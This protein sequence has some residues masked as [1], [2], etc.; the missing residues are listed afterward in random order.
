MV[1]ETHALNDCATARPAPPMG[2]QE[3][4]A[5]SLPLVELMA[6][7][8]AARIALLASAD[9]LALIPADADRLGQGARIDFLKF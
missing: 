7:N 5:I 4:R 6:P 2:W 1:V 9:G 8:F 3:A